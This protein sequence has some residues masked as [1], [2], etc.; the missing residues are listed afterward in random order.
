MNPSH[1]K[2]ERDYL[3]RVAE[4]LQRIREYTKDGSEQLLQVM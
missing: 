1:A 4:I 3:A 2:R